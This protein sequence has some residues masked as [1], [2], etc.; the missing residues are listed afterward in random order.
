MKKRGKVIK[1]NLD[2]KMFY[3]ILIIVVLAFGAVVVNA[4]SHPNPGHTASEIENLC[5]SDGTDCGFMS[6][7]YTITEFQAQGYE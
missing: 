1:I 5:Q 4:I 3:L 6:N 7:Y 2:N